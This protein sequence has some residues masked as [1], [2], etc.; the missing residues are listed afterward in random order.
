MRNRKGENV[1]LRWKDLNSGYIA[2]IHRHHKSIIK[3]GGEE[4]GIINQHEHVHRQTKHGIG[5]EV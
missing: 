3:L 5:L 4:Q 2:P 1:N